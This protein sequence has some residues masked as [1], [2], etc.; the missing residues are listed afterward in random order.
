MPVAKALRGLHA[1]PHLSDPKVGIFHLDLKPPNILVG[2]DGGGVLTDFGLATI[3]SGAAGRALRGTPLYAAPEQLLGQPCDGRADVWALALVLRFALTGKED[4][5]QSRDLNAIR[6]QLRQGRAP[7]PC[8][9]WVDIPKSLRDLMSRML[10][11]SVS[12]RPRCARRV[13]LGWEGSLP[14]SGHAAYA[15]R[16][17]MPAASAPRARSAAEV[18]EALVKVQQE[19][20]RELEQAAARLTCQAREGGQGGGVR[21]AGRGSGPLPPRARGAVPPLARNGPV[22]CASSS[23]RSRSRPRPA[24]PRRSA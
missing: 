16:I 5:Y 21:A 11:I 14:S 24:L 17:Q 15:R 3:A 9:E 22:H 7:A 23:T 13:E 10:K 2:E 20:E 8:P 6:E 12:L 19:K 4:W 18:Y 1:C